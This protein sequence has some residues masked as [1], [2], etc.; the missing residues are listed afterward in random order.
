VR[1]AIG[2]SAHTGW[3]AATV[4]GGN[5]DAP[6]VAAREHVE[7]LG[8]SE[9]FVFHHAAEAGSP[10]EAGRLVTRARQRG[11]LPV[12]APGLAD[13]AAHLDQTRVVRVE[14]V[15]RHDPS[16]QAGGLGGV[17]LAAWETL[18]RRAE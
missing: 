9:R 11:Q 18:G 1:L 10:D 7:L 15:R 8:E 6:S 4:A 13:D 16:R 2:L 5:I 3:A 14:R 17:P 12:P